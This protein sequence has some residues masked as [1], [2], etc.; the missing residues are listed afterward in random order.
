RFVELANDINDHMP[1]YVVRRISAALNRDRRSVNGSK[2]TLLGLAYKRN[3]GDAR[4]SPAMAIAERLL[5]MGAEVHAVDPHVVE[6]HVD[7][8]VLRVE[9]SAAELASADLVVLL[10]DHDAFDFDAVVAHSRAVLDT[11]HR[12]PQ[13]SNVEYL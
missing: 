11:R 5:S 9:A 7:E 6:A 13:A 1:D 2:V 12:L 10:T 8:R 3:T 4:E